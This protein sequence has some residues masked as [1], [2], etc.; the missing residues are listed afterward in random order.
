MSVPD[1]SWVS[2]TSSRNFCHSDPILDW[3]DR[4]GKE[5]GFVRDDELPGYDPETDM[6]LFMREKGKAFEAAVMGCIEGKFQIVRVAERAGDAKRQDLYEATLTAMENQVEMI[7]QPV[8]WDTERKMYGIPDLLVRSDV[9]GRLVEQPVEVPEGPVHYRVIDIKFTGLTL[10]S[11]GC[12]GNNA[13]DSRKK[14]QLLV[15]NRALGQMQGFEPPVAYLLGRSW[16]Q[17]VKSVKS[18][19]DSCL[20]RLAPADMTDPTLGTLVDEAAAWIRRVRDEGSAWDVLPVPSIVELYPNMGNTQDAPWHAAKKQ[21]GEHLGEVTLLWQVSPKHRPTA[22][23]QGVVRFN[24]E[25]QDAKVFGLAESYTAKLQR[26]L[27]IN[28]PLTGYTVLPEKISAGGDEWRDEQPLEFYVDFETVSDLDDDFSK[29]PN[30]GGQTLI[31]MIG[32]GHMENGEWVFKVFTCDRLDLASEKAIIDAWHEY[33]FLTETRLGVREP[34]VFHW[35]HA[36]RSF[37]DSAYN[38]ARVR[39]GAD[40]PELNWYDFLIKVMR[41]EPVVVKGALAFGLKHV[42][43]AMHKNG[44]IATSWED[45]P[46]DGLAAMVG[47]WSCDRM[48]RENGGSMRDLPLMTSIEKYNEVDCRVMQ[49]IIAYLRANH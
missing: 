25:R 37:L 41:E 46:G 8:V 17:T 13:S 49:E 24:D 28:V 36:E 38:S 31:F 48:A 21:I 45:G 16:S 6:G 7:F 4:F 19:S 33:M 3:L 9:L 12:V 11:T 22:H 47:A 14:A 26:I 2:A 5:K 44:M 29:L 15:Y 39:Q 42:A 10:S 1:E 30:K 18:R 35:S 34:R 20:N 32:C 40:W 43:K 23:A 27:D